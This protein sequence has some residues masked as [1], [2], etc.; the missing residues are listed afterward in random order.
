MHKTSLGNYLYKYKLKMKKNIY[1]TRCSSDM[2]EF[3]TCLNFPRI[4][5]IVKNVFPIASCRFSFCGK[6]ILFH[7]AFQYA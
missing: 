5:N 1:V 7:R 2:T 3:Y 6:D 4:M